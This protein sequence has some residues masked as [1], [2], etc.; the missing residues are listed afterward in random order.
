[1]GKSTFYTNRISPKHCSASLQNI[2]MHDNFWVNQNH[3]PHTTNVF[4]HAE[5]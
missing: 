5:L 3:L 4:P 1:M 2:F